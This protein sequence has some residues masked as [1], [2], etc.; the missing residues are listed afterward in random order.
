MAL[1][2]LDPVV[3]RSDDPDHGLKAGDLGTIVHAYDDGNVEVEFSLGSGEMHALVRLA[4]SEV[5]GL[6][7]EDLLAVRQIRRSA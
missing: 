4:P 6:A 7:S 5:R 2:E 1:K 3:L